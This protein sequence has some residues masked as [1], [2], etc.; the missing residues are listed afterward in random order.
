MKIAI[1]GAGITGLSAAVHLLDGNHEIT[2]LEKNS[3]S[4]GL[5]ATLDRFPHSLDYGAFVCYPALKSM[6][7]V[8]VMQGHVVSITPLRPIFWTTCCP[9]L[10]VPSPSRKTAR[11]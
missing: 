10:P 1:L 2:I 9:R 8:Q 6:L 4:G 11:S 3:F 7:P 5:A